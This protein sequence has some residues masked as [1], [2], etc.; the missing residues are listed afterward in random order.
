MMAELC[1]AHTSCHSSIIWRC[2]RR[3][4]PDISP[5]SPGS[6]PRTIPDQVPQGE[7]ARMDSQHRRLSTA[8]SVDHR[9]ICYNYGAADREAHTTF[10]MPLCGIWED[11]PTHTGT[12][13]QRGSPLGP[14][15]AGLIGPA[16]C[17]AAF[18]TLPPSLQCRA[19]TGMS[20]V[21][22]VHG[23]LC[24]GAWD[25]AGQA[26]YGWLVGSRGD[27]VRDGGEE[28]SALVFA[29]PRHPLRRSPGAPRGFPL[30]GEA[31][32]DGSSHQPHPVSAVPGRA[33]I[34]RHPS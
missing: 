33:R 15:R 1:S 10:E 32:G 24:V 4:W 29:R 12:T 23:S 16:A 30:M 22:A 5:L 14:T 18:G 2:N 7:A 19:P 28:E 17:A 21:G 26:W 3:G 11:P 20:R 25:S 9:Q 8:A 13:P 6:S 31:R 27:K 34:G